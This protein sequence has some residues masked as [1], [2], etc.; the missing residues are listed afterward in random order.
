[1]AYDRF[2]DPVTR[3]PMG[4]RS[5]ECAIS[6][7]GVGTVTCLGFLCEGKEVVKEGEVRLRV[8]GESPVCD[9]GFC[10]WSRLCLLFET[11]V[12]GRSELAELSWEDWGDSEVLVAV[13]LLVVDG[14][15]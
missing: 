5:R 9:G 12:Q 3:K 8:N 7:G 4:D 14:V 13:L 6:V 10:W 2:P 1:M 15:G 11:N